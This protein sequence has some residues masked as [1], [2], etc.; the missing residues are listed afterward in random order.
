MNTSKYSEEQEKNI[1][2]MKTHLK[3]LRLIA[4]WTSKELAEILGLSQQTILG[5]E[6][7]SKDDKGRYNYRISY[8]QYIALLTVFEQKANEDNNESLQA[9]LNLLFYETDIYEENQKKIDDSLPV[10]AGAAAGAAT[11]A[12][13]VVVGKTVAATILPFATTMLAPFGGIVA[14]AGIGTSLIARTILKKK[15]KK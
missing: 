2:T 4:G 1:I 10:L 5:F 3:S 14:L 13:G 9:L 11:V 7:Q 6:D 8:V 12:G 15:D